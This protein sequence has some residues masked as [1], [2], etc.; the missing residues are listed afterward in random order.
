[1]NFAGLFKTKSKVLLL[2]SAFWCFCR[3]CLD[4][5]VVC[6]GALPLFDSKA[7]LVVSLQNILFPLYMFVNPLYSVILSFKD[8]GIFNCLKEME[9]INVQFNVHQGN[10]MKI[11][12]VALV[13]CCF[14]P[15]CT[16]VSYTASIAKYDNYIQTHW[17]FLESSMLNNFKH[18]IKI[19][20]PILLHSVCLFQ[21]LFVILVVFLVD[22]FRKMNRHV[23]QK[24]TSENCKQ[25]VED[26][27][28]YQAQFQELASVL[29]HHNKNFT[30]FLGFNVPVW[31][32]LICLDIYAVR[33]RNRSVLYTT[34]MFLYVL[35]F[36][37]LLTT[38]LL[39]CS[40][41]KQEV[42]SLFLHFHLVRMQITSKS[43]EPTISWNF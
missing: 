5:A 16:I 9:S 39:W 13:L 23:S 19:M 31:T 12:I 15:V 24:I 30:L 20:N 10:K 28:K 25:T 3:L 43:T 18:F 26:L 4:A 38:T 34:Y 35:L 17:Y 6:T 27:C 37:I 32:A 21:F 11:L 40:L 22:Q 42:Q 33:I 7:D 1:M 2:V 29:G 36:L 8:N 41:L 14:M